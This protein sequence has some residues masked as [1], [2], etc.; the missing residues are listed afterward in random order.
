MIGTSISYPVISADYSEEDDTTKLRWLAA[1][2]KENILLAIQAVTVDLHT[3]IF[4]NSF[5]IIEQL[6]LSSVTF[7]TLM[8]P[9]LISSPDLK[10]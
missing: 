9:C 8:L 1:E 4:F 6:S 2:T 5:C 7:F 3:R 10:E